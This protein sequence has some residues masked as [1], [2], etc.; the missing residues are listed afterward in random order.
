METRD[1]KL[2][3]EVKAKL[4]GFLGFTV[5]ATFKYTFKV[6]RQKD[7]SGNFI[8][9]KETWPIFTLKSLDG[10]E[11]AK[12]EDSAGYVTLDTKLSETKLHLESGSSRI[13]TLEKGIKGVNNLILEDGS[14]LDFDSVQ[15]IITI[16]NGKKSKATKGSVKELIKYLRPVAQMELQEAINERSTLSDEELQ[17]LEF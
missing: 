4:D 8:V 6:F 9:P 12:R 2:T 5:E 17:G 7:E 15:E 11:A 1:L 16:R 13:S 10:L 3:P 14:V